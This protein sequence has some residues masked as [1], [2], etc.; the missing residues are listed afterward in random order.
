[1][2]VTLKVASEFVNHL[3][4]TALAP[5]ELEG[6]QIATVCCDYGGVQQRWFV[7][8]S[9]ERKK[10]DLKQLD[11]A[12]AKATIDWQAQL[13]QRCRQ[14]FACEADALAALKKFEQHLPWHQLEGGSVKQK[15]HYEKPG[16]PKQGTPPSRITYQPQ[17]SLT[18]NLTVVTMHQQ[19]AGR[20]ILP[21]NVLESEQLSA[22]QALEA[23]K[24]LVF[25]GV[26]LGTTSTPSSTPAGRPNL[27]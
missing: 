10:A 2:P 15:L 9:Q 5:T 25:A 13:R 14:E 20:F 26:Q 8:E 24:G 18:P 16:K 21:T 11:K 3:P 7:V 23:Y 6:Y 22:Q 19:R 12:L 4:E 1:M 27:T 17:A